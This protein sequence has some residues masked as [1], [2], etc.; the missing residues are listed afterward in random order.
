M[1]PL[2]GGAVAPVLPVGP[3]GH[4]IIIGG[5]QRQQGH[6]IQLLLLIQRFIISPPSLI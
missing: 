4:L 6:H 1:L 5:L 3:V 2:N